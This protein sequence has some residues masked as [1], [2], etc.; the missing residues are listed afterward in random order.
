M[1]H[2]STVKVTFF[3]GVKP[4]VES[5]GGVDHVY[6]ASSTKTWASAPSDPGEYLVIPIELELSE[7]AFIPTMP[8]VNISI[9]IESV[10]P[11]EV[12]VKGGIKRIDASKKVERKLS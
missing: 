12:K 2:G 8:K 7:E 9:P 3:L 1:S 10:E 6:K 4:K 5:R 11:A